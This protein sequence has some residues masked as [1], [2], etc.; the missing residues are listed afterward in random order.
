[1]DSEMDIEF[2]PLEILEGKK[3]HGWK[4]NH[5]EKWK[6]CVKL[7]FVWIARKHH[8]QYTL[9]DFVDLHKLERVKAST[10][11]LKLRFCMFEV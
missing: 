9:K 1:M 2:S 3:E 10:T 5:L 6:C 8:T 11:I 7:G 4:A